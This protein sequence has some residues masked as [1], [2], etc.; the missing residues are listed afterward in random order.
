MSFDKEFFDLGQV[1]NMFVP[2]EQVIVLQFLLIGH[3]HNVFIELSEHVK[4]CKGDVIAD[5][6]GLAL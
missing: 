6:K 5:E 1:L 2:P 3:L 4:I